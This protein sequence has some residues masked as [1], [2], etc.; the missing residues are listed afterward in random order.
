MRGRFVMIATVIALAI[1]SCGT[2]R[3]IVGAGT[4][5]VDSGFMA[6]LEDEFGG[7]LSIVAGSTAELLE[8]AA[9]GALDAV[10]VHDEA[11]ETAFM[12]QH[13]EAQRASAFVSQFLLVGPNDL[14]TQ[15]AADDPAAVFAEIAHNEWL[16]VTRADGS[17]THSRELAIWRGA[18]IEPGG[19]WY[20]ATGQG[21]GLTLQ[22]ADQMG[23]FTL[24]EEGVFIGAV[25]T[26]DLVV[27]PLSTTLV[28]DYSVLV[29]D[30]SGRAF[31]DWL[32]SEAG[33]SAVD[34]ANNAVFGR[35]VY[36]PV[37]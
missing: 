7:D 20:V 19:G 27:V 29:T 11:Q 14:V 16:F 25:D 26:I 5:L 23:G 12:V 36:A 18:A 24:V 10:I 28:N 37:R 34:A 3:V 4:T 13:P 9:R 6:E 30:D 21:M 8:L 22:V 17:G 33:R 1:A 2:N 15:L 32:T 31:F 35:S